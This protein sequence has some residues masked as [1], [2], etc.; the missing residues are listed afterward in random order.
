MPASA[1]TAEELARS[2]GD[3]RCELVRGRLVPM[4]PVGFEHGR[5]VMRFGFL[6]MQHL[7]EHSTGVVGTEIGFILE[8]HPDTVRAPDVA[9]VRHERLPGRDARGFFLGAPDLAV[10]VLSPDDREPDVQAKVAEYLSHGVG[11]VVVID[12]MRRSVQVMRPD[13]AP[14]LVLDHEASIDLSAVVPGFRCSLG[15]VFD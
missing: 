1:I 8:R 7:T 5:V 9:F 2:S 15:S 14:L 11:T 3:R 10:E 4:S 12:P 6:L 13:T